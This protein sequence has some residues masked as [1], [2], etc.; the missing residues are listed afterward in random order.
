MF[1]RNWSAKVEYLHIDL[2]N[3]SATGI[4]A[5]N[6]NAEGSD[7]VGYS[8]HNKFDTVRAGVNYHFN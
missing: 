3:T 4:E 6:G 2:G 1:A 7:L 5:V 8:W